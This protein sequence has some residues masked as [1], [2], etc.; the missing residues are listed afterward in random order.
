ME[1][2]VDARGLMCPQPV[3]KAKAA[4][5]DMR[6]GTLKILV[7]NEIAVQNVMKLAPAHRRLCRRPG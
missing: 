6:S 3:I 1:K 4:L 7:D 2:I 5:K